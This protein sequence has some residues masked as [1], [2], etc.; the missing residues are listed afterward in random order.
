MVSYQRDRLEEFQPFFGG[1]PKGA[2]LV[3]ALFAGRD[4]TERADPSGLLIELLRADNYNN[5]QNNRG[6]RGAGQGPDDVHQDI[7]D[8]IITTAQFHRSID[9]SS[10]AGTTFGV[11]K[12]RFMDSLNSFLNAPLPTEGTKVIRVA[13]A[14]TVLD[15]KEELSDVYGASNI[16]NV[17]DAYI[18]ALADQ[19]AWAA[20]SDSSTTGATGTTGR[21]APDRTILTYNKS[22][23][24][25]YDPY[26]LIHN[27]VR[28]DEPSE[29][30]APSTDD[31]YKNICFMSF[32]SKNPKMLRKNPGLLSASDALDE[33]E[34]SVKASGLVSFDLRKK[35]GDITEKNLEHALVKIAIDMKN[36][37]LDA[38]HNIST[39]GRTTNGYGTFNSETVTAYVNSNKNKYLP[40]FKQVVNTAFSQAIDQAIISTAKIPHTT[41]AKKPALDFFNAVYKNWSEMSPDAQAFYRANVAVF[42]RAGT[43]GLFDPANTAAR[44]QHEG[45]KDWVLLTPSELDNLQNVSYNPDNLRVNLM[46]RHGSYDILFQSNLPDVPQGATV[47]YSQRNGLGTVQNA[48]ANFFRNLYYSV[49]ANDIAKNGTI[50][51]TEPGV[52]G[53]SVRSVPGAMSG[54]ATAPSATMPSATTPSA[55]MA[56]TAPSATAPSATMA[57]AAAPSATMAAATTPSASGS[58][59]APGAAKRGWWD[60][61]SMGY[62]ASLLPSISDVASWTDPS[63]WDL[64]DTDVG[65]WGGTYTI[66]L[67][68]VENDSTRRPKTPY[69]LNHGKFVAAVIKREDELQNDKQTQTQAQQTAPDQCKG[70]EGYSFLHTTDM[71]YGHVWTFDPYRKQHFRMQDNRKVWYDDDARF[72]AK[73]CYATYLATK[74]SNPTGD[75]KRVLEC[76]LDGNPKNLSRC[77]DVIGDASLWD[78]AEDDAFKVGPDKVRLVLRKFG[79]QAEQLT[80]SNGN[81]FKIPVTF[82]EWKTG[83]VDKLEDPRVKNTINKNTKL[84]N[85]IRGLISVCRSNPSILNENNPS[86][87]VRENAPVY[88][89][90][91]NMKKYMLP[92]ASVKAQYEFFA[93]SLRNAT[94]P[95]NVNNDLWN[96]IINGSM[97]NVGFFSPYTSFA[98]RMMGGNFY[99]SNLSNVAVNPSL[100][101]RGTSSANFDRQVGLLRNGSANI[102]SALMTTIVNAMNDVGLK[103]HEDDTKKIKETIRQLEVYE[104]QLARMCMVLNHIVKLA[105]FYGVSLE[106]VDKN[107]L[108]TL[109]KLQDVHNLED[110]Q[111]FVRC[112][113]REIT[114]NML[115]NMSIQQG[116]SYELMNVVGPRF[117]DNVSG[118]KGDTSCSGYAGSKE[119][120]RVPI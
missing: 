55:T 90:N 65:Q 4:Y 15:S 113:A 66:K 87:Q 116:T 35:I 18:Y 100:I 42:A 104:D 8:L 94:M 12:K 1:D 96:P 22:P 83:F 115:T 39:D 25:E 86:I 23:N 99:A 16:V 37:L 51:V 80:D 105:R 27:M 64:E 56:A 44:E 32:I 29:P 50:V 85:Y 45:P 7:A 98:P 106:N 75:C 76:L 38:Y 26:T 109:I 54:T 68:D 33:L 17:G 95:R 24:A 84:L 103:M 43:V 78:I 30:S 2:Y 53:A 74:T 77:L 61:P 52:P 93:E 48:P 112:Y 119:S 34:N 47:W 19:A 9:L 49:Y 20:H 13:Y 107:R 31:Y 97:S 108:T 79:V 62:M 59:A 120:A 110:I 92:S 81:T 91:L 88:M 60:M 111:N 73:T 102:F 10:T 118:R 117:M 46:K 21:K 11:A 82:E 63:T 89:Q 67:Q 28:C 40:R 72:S 114:K 36:E 3:Q 41:F 101:S 57:A 6:T 5:F 58:A 70:L 69:A 71:A 14:T